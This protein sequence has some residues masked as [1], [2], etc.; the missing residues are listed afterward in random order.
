MDITRS[1]G[2]QMMK[3]KAGLNEVLYHAKLAVKVLLETY[4]TIYQSL[5]QL[6]PGVVTRSKVVYIISNSINMLWLFTKMTQTI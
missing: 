5:S 1:K 2:N 3:P 6:F 4:Q